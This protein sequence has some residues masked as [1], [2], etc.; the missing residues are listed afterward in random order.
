MRE[1]LVDASDPTLAR[2]VEE[3]KRTGRAHGELRARH[4]DGSVFPV[5]IS[6][7]VFQDSE[8]NKFTCIMLRN[9]S[10]RKRIETEREQL[11]GELREAL[12]KVKLLSG[13][14]SI[15]ASCKNI[16]NEDGQWEP[17]ETYIRNRSSADFSHGFCPE[18]LRKLYPGST[19]R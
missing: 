8:G 12:G 16:R 10:P 9:I 4:S 3:R 15:C 17:L 7:V 18:C 13:L 6:S 14:L 2:L 11:I 19:P 5:E 1:D